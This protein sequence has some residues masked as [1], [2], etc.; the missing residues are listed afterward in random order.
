MLVFKSRA[1]ACVHGVG[2]GIRQGLRIRIW[3]LAKDEKL[4]LGILIQ[5]HLK[6]SNLFCLHFTSF[7]K[8]I[9]HQKIPTSR[10]FV[11][12]S[13]LLTIVLDRVHMDRVHMDRLH[14]SSNKRVNAMYRCPIFLTRGFYRISH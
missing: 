5:S 3:E 9:P 1:C 12:I 13:H 14:T 10:L 8:R 2:L 6:I 7:N 4:G 11:Y